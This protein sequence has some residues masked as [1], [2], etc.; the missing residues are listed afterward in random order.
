MALILEI[1]GL[2][3]IASHFQRRT[4]LCFDFFAG[5]FSSVSHNILG[6]CT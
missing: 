4:I 5:A 2:Y 6:G 3:Q 1:T